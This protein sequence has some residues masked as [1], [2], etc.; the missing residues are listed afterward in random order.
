MSLDE[1][2]PK[3]KRDAT[4]QLRALLESDPGLGREERQDVALGLNVVA[5]NARDLDEI[6]DR[7]VNEPHTPAEVGELLIAFQLTLGQIS[8]LRISSTA[9]SMT[10]VTGSRP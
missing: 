1:E 10:S 6:L 5:D 9:N 3:A 2:F 8:V 4:R 7:L